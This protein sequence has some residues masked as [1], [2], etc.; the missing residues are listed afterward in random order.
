MINRKFIKIIIILLFNNL[1][2]IS[3]LF[4]YQNDSPLKGL[5]NVPSDVTKSIPNPFK[6]R[7]PKR[8]KKEIVKDPNL[9]I[10][11]HQLRTSFRTPDQPRPVTEDV[12]QPKL[13]P[14]VTAPN[15][16]ISGLVWNSNRPQAI[17]NGQ[18]VSIGDTVNDVKIMNIKKTGVEVSYQGVTM[19]IKP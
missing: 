8:E 4:A 7:L 16:N 5:G 12:S 9:N 2:I 6:T 3:N 15:L 13:K 1:F 18:V 17:I 10:E 11:G 19:T 14:V